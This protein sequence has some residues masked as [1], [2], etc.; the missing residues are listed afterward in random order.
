MKVG[1]SVEEEYRDDK[2][3]EKEI[4]NTFTMEL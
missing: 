1:V 2:I 3:K 4:I